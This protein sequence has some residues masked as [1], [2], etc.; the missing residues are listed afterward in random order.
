MV[1]SVPGCRAPDVLG[2]LDP[3]SRA[4]VDHR[5]VRVLGVPDGDQCLAGPDFDAVA[6]GAAVG[7]LPPVYLNHVTYCDRLIT[8]R[9]QP[10][11][12]PAQSVTNSLQSAHAGHDVHCAT[13]Q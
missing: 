9:E 4:N 7:G 6:V 12:R 5:P 2:E 3:C 8:T 1:P 11:A 10:T 13:G